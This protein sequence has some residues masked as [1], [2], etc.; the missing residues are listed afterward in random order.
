MPYEVD[1][2]FRVEEALADLPERGRQEVMEV[3]AGVLVRPDSWPAPGGW[4]G[5]LAFGPRSWVAF[6]AH[7]DGIEV[8]DAGWAGP[9]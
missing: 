3:I 7:L 5:A 4:A 9:A 1:L 6:T 8:Y 2:A